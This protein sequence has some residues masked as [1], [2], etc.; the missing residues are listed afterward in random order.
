MSLDEASSVIKPT[1]FLVVLGSFFLLFLH[2]SWGRS[3]SSLWVALFLHFAAATAARSF[4]STATARTATALVTTT[5][6]A[7]ATAAHR[8]AAAATARTMREQAA[9]ATTERTTVATAARLTAAVAALSA[10]IATT[11]AAVATEPESIG[12]ARNGQHGHH[13]SNTLKVHLIHLHLCTGRRPMTSAAWRTPNQG[14]A[15]QT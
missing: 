4:V 6:A 10:R 14:H 1:L 13:Q 9:E 11:A 15:P 12:A 3:R 5:T 2:R 8:A 7:F